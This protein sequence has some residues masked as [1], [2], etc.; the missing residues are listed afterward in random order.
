MI[1]IQKEAEEMDNTAS[2]DNTPD[3][4]D[5]YLIEPLR[6]SSVVHKFT[7]TFGASLD[8]DK[9]TSTI[10]AFNHYIMEDTACLMAFADLQGGYFFF[11]AFNPLLVLK[12]F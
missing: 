12:Y 3:I 7:G 4:V 10:L 2:D 1:L 9:L 5:S 8:T 11:L 6:T